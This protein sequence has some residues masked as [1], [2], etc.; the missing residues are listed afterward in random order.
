M[1]ITCLSVLIN[2]VR[3]CDEWRIIKINDSNGNVHQIE[4]ILN[5]H[6]KSQV[7]ACHYRVANG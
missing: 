6:L 3:T 2:L 7:D 4:L 1:L 5:R